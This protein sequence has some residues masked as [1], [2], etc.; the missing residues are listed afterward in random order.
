MGLIQIMVRFD[1]HTRGIN[2]IVGMMIFS[3]GAG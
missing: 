3:I 2:M 1:I